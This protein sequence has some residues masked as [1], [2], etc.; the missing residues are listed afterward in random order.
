MSALKRPRLVV[1]DGIQEPQNAGSSSAPTKILA[2]DIGG[3]KIKMLVTGATEPRKLPSGKRL[4][5]ARLM[6]AIKELAQD[7]DYEAVSIG[8]PGLVGSNGPRS[9]PLNLGPGWVGFNYGAAFDR[10]VRIVND[11]AMQALGSYE[12]GRMLFLG[13]G[14]GLGAAL[15]ADKAIVTLELGRLVYKD[16]RTFG[17]TLGRK[18]LDRAGKGPWREAVGDIVP[19]L[20][21]AFVADYVVIGGGNAK[22]VRKLPAGARLGH[23]NTAFRGGFRLWH[24]EDLQTLVPQGGP[25]APPKEAEQWRMI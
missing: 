2:V 23:N 4:T 13:L 10:P 7:W 1:P 9:E 24:V 11:A 8:Y 21:A 15:I 6:D 3:T 19:T 20:M 14:T 18:G 16:G 12:G 17:E 22:L 5:P 25:P